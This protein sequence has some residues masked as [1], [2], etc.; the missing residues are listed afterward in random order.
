MMARRAGAGGCGACGLGRARVHLEQ[1]V[2]QLEAACLAW[3]VWA[4][5]IRQLT[6][7]RLGISDLLDERVLDDPGYG[8]ALDIGGPVGTAVTAAVAASR[9]AQNACPR[10]GHLGRFDSSYVVQVV[11]NIQPHR[12]NRSCVAQP[13]PH[14]T[15]EARGNHG[16]R[17]APRTGGRKDVDAALQFKLKSLNPTCL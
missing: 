9:A 13:N 6:E 14:G 8:R 10:V 15:G 17:R 3:G 11:A 4:D 5:G 2:A 12:A 16:G 1:A 7:Q